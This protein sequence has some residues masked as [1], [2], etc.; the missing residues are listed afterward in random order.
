MA[1]KSKIVMIKNKYKWKKRN[2]HNNTYL[3]SRY[4]LNNVNVGRYTY[5]PIDVDVVG[6]EA[7]LEI[8]DF[9]SIADGVKFIIGESYNMENF[10]TFPFKAFWGEGEPDTKKGNIS[11]GNDVWLGCRSLV[12]PGVTI[13][14]GAVIG[15]GAI[16]CKDVPPYAIVGG[17]PASIIKYRFD[18]AKINKLLMIDFSKIDSDYIMKHMNEIY[19]HTIPK[20]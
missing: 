18:E 1:L 4:G 9:C 15:A 8:G 2:K 6:S 17:C 13:G 10:S 14:Q 7:Q 11:V 12:L 16:V 3:V 5:G 20:M 19:E